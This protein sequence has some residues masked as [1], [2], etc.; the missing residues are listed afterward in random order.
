MRNHLLVAKAPVGRPSFQMR[1]PSELQIQKQRLILQSPSSPWGAG[2]TFR[3]HHAIAGCELPFVNVKKCDTQ[4][5]R[6]ILGEL[7]APENLQTAIDLISKE[8]SGPYE[9]QASTVSTLEGQIRKVQEQQ[10][11]V[12][13]AYEAGAY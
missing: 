7:F 2:S 9:Q 11:R 8:L 12:M 13:Q 1:K 10:E 3:K 6:V 5:L 4:V